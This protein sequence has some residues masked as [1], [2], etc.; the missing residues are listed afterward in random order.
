MS[1]E[2]LEKIIS[3]FEEIGAKKTSLYLKEKVNGV[4]GEKSEELILEL[5]KKLGTNGSHTSFRKEYSKSPELFKQELMNFETYYFDDF[6]SS[7]PIL[8]D[9]DGFFQSGW[10]PF[11]SWLLI[12][13]V[14]L[15]STIIP[16]INALTSKNIQM[17]PWDQIT[18]F[19]GIWLVIYSG[20]NTALRIFGDKKDDTGSRKA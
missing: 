6:I 19:A 10:R 2:N 5:S 17:M 8:K 15:N 3:L 7:T 12:W 18:A 13:L 11:M 9:K 20:G 4:G 14:M 1:T 16:F